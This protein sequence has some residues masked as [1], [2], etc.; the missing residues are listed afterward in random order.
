MGCIFRISS[1]LIRRPPPHHDSYLVV[2]GLVAI[3]ESKMNHD[4]G[5]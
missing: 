5:R 2:F 3:G 4:L 1:H